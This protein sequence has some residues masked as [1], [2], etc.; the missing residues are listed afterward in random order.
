MPNNLGNGGLG[1]AVFEPLFILN[2]ETGEI[3]PWLGSSASSNDGLDVW[4]L[5]L[6]EGAEWADGHPF[7]SGDVVFS[8][9]LLLND[10]TSSLSY[11]GNVQTW[12][13]SVEAVDDLTVQFNLTQPNPR[14]QLD[15]FS[16]RIW[17]GINMLPEHV[18]AD[19]DPYTF[20]N[21][22]PEQGWPMGTGPYVLTS[23]TRPPGSTIAMTIGGAPKRVSSSC[24]SRNAPSG[25]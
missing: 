14:F 12:I 10:E 22:D 21:F 3:M 5:N 25:L 11:A 23:A 13:E 2:Y 16:V 15:F 7:D 1:Q 19:K 4:T 8:I 24:L 9:E 20:N 6:H 18:W 17:G